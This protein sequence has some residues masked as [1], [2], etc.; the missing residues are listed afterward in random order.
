MAD[1]P[2]KWEAG[3]IAALEETGNVSEAAKAAGVGR[4]TVYDYKEASAE[5][6]KKWEFALAGAAD[7]LEA[8]AIRQAVK[9]DEEP[10]FSQ[11]KVVGYRTRK[12]PTLLM[13]MIRTMRERSEN[14]ARERRIREAQAQW[15]EA[16]G[17]DMLGGPS[18]RSLFDGEGV[19]PANGNGARH[20]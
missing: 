11:G 8:E 20:K 16:T 9:G 5:F 12:S 1:R 13:F 14:M 7:I 6:A 17:G 4:Q 18:L 15:E 19:G 3:F 2:R 10:V